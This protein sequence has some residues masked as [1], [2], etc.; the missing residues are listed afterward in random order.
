MNE[1][2]RIA[3]RIRDEFNALR[4]TFGQANG[5]A[6][7]N[8]SGKLPDSQLS[9]SGKTTDA[10]AEGSTNRY[11]TDARAQNALATS[12]AAKQDISEKGTANGYASLD[13]SGTV[14]SAQLPAAAT[15]SRVGEI[16]I[17]ITS[18]PPQGVVYFNRASLSRTS[19]ADLWAWVQ[20]HP[21]LYDDTGTDK[22]KF[23]PGDDST[24]FDL[25]DWKGIGV[26]GAGTSS[27][28]Q[29]ANG[30]YYDGGNLLDVLLDGLKD[31]RHYVSGYVYYGNSTFWIYYSGTGH[32]NEAVTQTY[33]AGPAS[34]S[35]GDPRSTDE[36]RGVTVAIHWGI[37]YE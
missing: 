16:G 28:F 30:N 21:E 11:F 18:T 4:A 34:N 6:T 27:A 10:L 19:Y 23:G 31:H 36:N 33:T 35:S 13:S 22:Q 5:V 1:L 14:P 2:K 8:A 25:P 15:N 26:R 20:N 9:L 17:F 24:T 32:P 29:K 12:L 37:R 3:G 7:L